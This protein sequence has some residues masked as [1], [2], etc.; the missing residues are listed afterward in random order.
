MHGSFRGRALFDR[1]TSNVTR[2]ES[3]YAS[4]VLLYIVESNS[5]NTTQAGIN[6]RATF[7]ATRVSCRL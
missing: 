6:I 2:K 4:V 1:A 5:Q 7:V 3:R